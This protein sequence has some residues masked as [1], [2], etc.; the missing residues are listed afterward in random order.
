M[1]TCTLDRAVHPVFSQQ[2]EHIVSN[3]DPPLDTTQTQVT[4]HRFRHFS[5]DPFFAVAD[6]CHGPS[7][8]RSRPFRATWFF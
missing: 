7:L 4:V 1:Y 2:F 3:R 5:H 6:L 8:F